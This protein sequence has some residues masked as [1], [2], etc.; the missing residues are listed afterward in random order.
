MKDRFVL[1]SRWQLACDIDD[2]WR[3]VCAIRLWPR[4][5]PHVK[6]VRAIGGGDDASATPRTGDSA[7]VE[8][9]TRLGYGLRIHV[10][11]TAVLAPFELE[12]VATGDL[13]G[14]GLWVLESQHG[15][16]N[17]TYRWDVHLNRPWMRWSAPALRPVFAWNHF[18]IMRAGARGMAGSIGCK[19]I[20]YEDYTV[21]PHRA[22]E[23]PRTPGWLESTLP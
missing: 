5:W 17:I 22:A 21:P 14:T 9:T 3:H 6:A 13:S 20:G 4:W 15:H 1:I 23:A 11:T 18:D 10:T 19:L 2:A 7:K 12:A 8:W 16:V